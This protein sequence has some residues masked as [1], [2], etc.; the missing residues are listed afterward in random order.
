MYQLAVIGAG[1]IGSRHLQA[2]SQL[3]HK[4]QIHVVDPGQ[5]SLQ[6]ARNRLAE[7]KENPNVVDYH[8]HRTVNDL[9]PLLDY[10]V[11]STSA[12]IRLSVMRNLLSI[13]EVRA[14]VLE[15]VL[16]TRVQDYIDSIDLLR[17]FQVPT[18]VNCTR[19]A[20]S[21]YLELKDML[22]EQQILDFKVCGGE[23]G[24]GC[25]GIHFIDL[26]AFLSD[27]ANLKLIDARNLD[28][29]YI[30]SKRPSFVEFTGAISGCLDDGTSF[31]IKSVRGTDIRRLIEIRTERFTILI[32]EQSNELTLFDEA[33]GQW[34]HRKFQCPFTSDVMKDI[35]SDILINRRCSLP[36]H[37]ESVSHH[38]P[39]IKALLSHQGYDLTDR[40]VECNIT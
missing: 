40:L 20:F 16:Y 25:N 39:F 7:M 4:C 38:L 12:N 17:E 9:P 33:N 18:W 31:E 14:F 37:E 11:L 27:G 13:C 28:D 8:F 19:R 6:T 29:G 1:Q 35:A 15:K 36:S 34:E 10:V 32:D 3:E 5:K 24:L 30:K 22:R 2:L 23:W 26:I 21:S